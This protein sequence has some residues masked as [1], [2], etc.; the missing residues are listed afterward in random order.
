MMN[1]DVDKR[2]LLKGLVFNY[3]NRKG[4]MKKRG[5]FFARKNVTPVV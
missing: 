5:D 3:E 1:F 2:E 4:L